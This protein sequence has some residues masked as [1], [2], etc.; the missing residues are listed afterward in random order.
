[1]LGPL[2]PTRASAK[3]KPHGV[4]PHCAM[5]ALHTYEAIGYDIRRLSNDCL[6]LAMVDGSGD[7]SA[8]GQWV[9]YL[10]RTPGDLS[11]LGRFQKTH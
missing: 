10:G 1:M 11:T 6:G 2:Q 3:P 8:T 9:P 7:G 5:H 4:D